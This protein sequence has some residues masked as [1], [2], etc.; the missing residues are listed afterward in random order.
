MCSASINWPLGSLR[1]LV[2]AQ[3]LRFLTWHSLSIL[4]IP[5][6]ESAITAFFLIADLCIHFDIRAHDMT[7]RD[8]CWYLRPSILAK[9]S[10]HLMPRNLGKPLR[11]GDQS[12]RLL[13]R[14]SVIQAVEDAGKYS[15]NIS[16]SLLKVCV[17]CW[18][19]LHESCTMF[20]SKLSSMLDICSPYSS[21]SLTIMADG[22]YRDH[23]VKFGCSKMQLWAAYLRLC[24]AAV[25]AHP[26]C[27]CKLSNN[28]IWSYV[29]HELCQFWSVISRRTE[30]QT[31]DAPKRGWPYC[32]TGY[33][34]W[35]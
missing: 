32:G 16:S 25:M 24:L 29:T 15:L 8:Q 21:P 12:N 17:D 14:A 33:M 19:Q 11:V 10:E 6:L 26:V 30:M 18:N 4:C 13:A 3:W 9:R 35:V 20:W 28:W 22:S 31:P 5:W 34:I 1:L 7:F 27:C 2:N 23:T